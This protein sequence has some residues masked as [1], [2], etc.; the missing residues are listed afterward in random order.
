MQLVIM[1]ND[2]LFR[3]DK[4]TRQYNFTPIIFLKIQV[5]GLIGVVFLCLSGDAYPVVGIYR[6]QAIVKS[7]MVQRIE[8]KAVLG[9]C[10]LS[11]RVALLPRFYVAGL[12]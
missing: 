11:N 10:S 1:E 7:L 4:T 3:G 9:I 5:E 12:Q 8:T 2:K 6:N